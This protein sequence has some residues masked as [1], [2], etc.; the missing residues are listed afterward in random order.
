MYIDSKAQLMTLPVNVV[1][2]CLS[3]CGQTDMQVG[4]ES[5]LEQL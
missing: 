2:S 1:R 3:S 5:L 4:F